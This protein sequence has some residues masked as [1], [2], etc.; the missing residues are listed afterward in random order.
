MNAQQLQEEIKFTKWSLKKLKKI[1][2]GRIAE[3]KYTDKLLE[4]NPN[5][6][7]DDINAI[8]E[9]RNFNNQLIDTFRRQYADNLKYLR[10][11]DTTNINIPHNKKNKVNNKNT[12]TFLGKIFKKS[13][14]RK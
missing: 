7:L 11:Y 14:K 12:K 6:S 2:N 1:I 5:G 4:R 10:K 3:N 9:S 8:L 13:L